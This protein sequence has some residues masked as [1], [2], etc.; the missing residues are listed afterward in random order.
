VSKTDS[1]RLLR[2][3]ARAEI[4]TL[5]PTEYPTSTKKPAVAR[6]SSC[7]APV[8]W[9]HNPSGKWQPMNYDLV[10][11]H[12]TSEPHHATCAARARR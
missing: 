8:W 6:C 1:V 2:E 12:P 9:R 3:R 10:T 4:S 5:P 11:A 7:Q